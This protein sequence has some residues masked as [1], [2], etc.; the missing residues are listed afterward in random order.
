M[1]NA[2]T[3]QGS[4]TRSGAVSLLVSFLALLL[5]AQLLSDIYLVASI[6]A[7]AAACT[8]LLNVLFVGGRNDLFLF[9][10]VT[11]AMS[12]TIPYGKQRELDLV[13]PMLF[14]GVALIRFFPKFL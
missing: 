2:L 13:I 7:F 3:F 12:I 14:F 6:I 8:V 10:F 9:L 4:S 1:Y 11:T 5:F